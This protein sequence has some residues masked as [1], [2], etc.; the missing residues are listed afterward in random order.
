MVFLIE[1]GENVAAWVVL[2]SALSCFFAAHILRLQEKTAFFSEAT[3][4]EAR[5]QTAL[6][7]KLS[8]VSP[9][10]P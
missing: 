9:P 5:M 6:L 7:E 3:A 1:K 4:Q 10:L 2:G 8:K